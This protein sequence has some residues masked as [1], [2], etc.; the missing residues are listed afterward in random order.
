MS[1]RRLGLY[2]IAILL[3]GIGLALFAYY[4]FYLVE[5]RTVHI[6][7]KV[8]TGIGGMNGD[9][10]ALHFGTITPGG[11]SRRFMS[12]TSSRD[13][14]LVISFGGNASPFLEVVPKEMLVQKGVPVSLN[15]TAVVPENTTEGFYSGKAKF[16]FYRS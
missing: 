16:Y 9:T 7:F 15:F 10:D 3:I 4:D 2:L 6:D 8:A 14:R 1:K 5:Y 12:V 11:W 13:A